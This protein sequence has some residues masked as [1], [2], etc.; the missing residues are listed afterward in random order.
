MEDND[1]GTRRGGNPPE[2]SGPE[3]SRAEGIV[4]RHRELFDS[5]TS[6]ERTVFFSDAVFAIAMTLLVLELIIPEGL[7]QEHLGEAL[8]EAVPEFIAY[9]ISFTVLAIA[10][11]SH[12]RKFTVIHR[13]DAPLQGLNLLLLFFI[14][15][16]PMPT[17]FLSDY[18][19]ELSP[20]PAVLYAVVTS[21]V[22]LVLD[23]IWW[24]AWRAGLI[25][26][27]VDAPM[28]RYMLWAMLPVPVV[29]LLSIPVAFVSADWAM[30]IWVLIIPALFLT[31]RR[32]HPRRP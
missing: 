3:G 9:T 32:P 7:D 6:V 29:F 17:S 10:W 30:F 13:Y 20:W 22:F 1:G 18:G 4:R 23:L 12:H 19:G 26:P 15:V 31:R 16:L 27:V 5:G 21:A 8:A 11:L 24:H 28:Y 25:A 2:P 14:A